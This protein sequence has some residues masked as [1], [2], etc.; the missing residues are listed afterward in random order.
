MRKVRLF[1]PL[2]CRSPGL[3]IFPAK[4]RVKR[5]KEA[6]ATA[7]SIRLLMKLPI[8]FFDNYVYMYDASI[9]Y[10]LCIETRKILQTYVNLLSRVIE[11]HR[12]RT[13]CS[14]ETIRSLSRIVDRSM[15]IV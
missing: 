1:F 8:S 15:E 6:R 2:L 9:C 5:K 3:K 7:D 4:A 10:Q 12:F 11:S 13:K 14:L